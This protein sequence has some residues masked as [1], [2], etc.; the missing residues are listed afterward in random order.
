MRQ[1][2][3][4][5]YADTFL[6]EYLTNAIA[7]AKHNSLTL[8]GLG[9]YDEARDYLSRAKA[10]Q[11]LVDKGKDTFVNLEKLKDAKDKK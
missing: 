7:V 10:L 5:M 6:R 2:L 1:G 3:A 11:Q 4:R 9:K 8:L